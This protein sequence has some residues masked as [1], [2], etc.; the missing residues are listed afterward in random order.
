MELRIETLNPSRSSTDAE[1]RV[2]TL[3]LEKLAD[4]LAALRFDGHL[5]VGHIE[6]E[7]PIPASRIGQPPFVGVD[8]LAEQIARQ[9]MLKLAPQLLRA[10]TRGRPGEVPA[11][12][13]QTREEREVEAELAKANEEL[14][15]MLAESAAD[16]AGIFD[17]TPTSDLVGAGLA[18][19]RGDVLGAGLNMLSMIPYVGD[20]VGKSIK[21]TRLATR[22]VELRARI[23][24]LVARL[25]ALR[26]A[27][28]RAARTPDLVPGNVPSRGSGG[29]GGRPP[30]PPS[31]RPDPGRPRPNRGKILHGRVDDLFRRWRDDEITDELLEA[32]VRKV[33]QDARLPGPIA[34]LVGNLDAGDL[35]KIVYSGGPDFFQLAHHQSAELRGYLQHLIQSSLS[36]TLPDAQ[37]V[38]MW[39]VKN[40]ERLAQLPMVKGVRDV[41]GEGR[42]GLGLIYRGT[43]DG[44]D[45]IIKADRTIDYPVSE[46]SQIV[47]Q[48]EDYGGPKHYGTV[49]VEDPRT[50]VWREAVAMERIVGKDMQSLLEG[51]RRGEPLPVQVGKKHLDAIEALEQRL[52]R[53][54]KHLEEVNLGDFML[55]HDPERAVAPLDM[56]VKEGAKPHSGMIGPSGK[57]VRDSLLEVWARSTRADELTLTRTVADHAKTRP[58]NDSRLLMQ[59]VMTHG[60]VAPDPRG[61]QN[62]VRFEMEGSTNFDNAFKSQLKPVGSPA[63]D[64]VWELVVDLE[65]KQV[66]HWLF[67]AK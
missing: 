6:V 41:T 39:S 17:P 34:Q 63:R 65:K 1:R 38:Y 45:A 43:V 36:G 22:L 51:A 64:G 20:A 8:Q 54:G 56:F 66:L 24:A 13:G 2:A 15:W 37:K 61:A 52:A 33:L 16:V 31:N 26:Q 46:S 44:K 19:R 50:G 62:A 57:S 55:T 25:R 47:K 48:L 28:V 7:M 30:E 35:G 53:E 5:D 67:K 9:I 4:R 12:S 3:A 18:L 29:G 58:Y 23:A 32:E 60:K 21:G 11:G 49:R 40:A 42:G 10:P 59:E 27:R 14:G